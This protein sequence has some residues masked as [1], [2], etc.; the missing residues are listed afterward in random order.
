MRPGQQLQRLPP[1]S[2]YTSSM[3]VSQMLRQPTLPALSR[4]S[5]SSCLWS[6]VF[7]S[8][9]G[10]F[11]CFCL[12]F[13]PFFLLSCCLSVSW[14]L[15][16]LVVTARLTLLSSCLG[17]GAGLEDTCVVVAGARVVVTPGDTNG[18]N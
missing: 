5:P 2:W 7:L 9:D 10:F 17:L 18:L 15:A 16:V 3:R 1:S 13:F 6:C 11:F 12:V 14:L 8:F 4:S